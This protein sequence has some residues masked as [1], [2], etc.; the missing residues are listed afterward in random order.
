MSLTV[1]WETW[2][3]AIYIVPVVLVLNTNVLYLNNIK[4]VYNQLL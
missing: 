1:G 4:I 3:Y 2:V